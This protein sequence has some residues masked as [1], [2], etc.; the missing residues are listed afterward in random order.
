MPTYGYILESVEERI[1]ERGGEAREQGPTVIACPVCGEEHANALELATHLGGT[2]PLSAPRLLI[3]GEAVVGERVLD[4]HLDRGRLTVANANELLVSQDG[5]PAAPWSLEALRDAVAEN[6]HALLDLELRNERAADQA[7]ATERVRLRID[8]PDPRDLAAVEE[9]F[10]VLA[11]AELDE[12]VVDAF[13]DASREFPSA[14]RYAS[15]LHEYA[16]GVLIKNRAPGTADALGFERFHEKYHRALDVLHHF[17]ER[18]LACAVGGFLRFNLND[19]HAHAPESGVPV[20]DRCCARLTSLATGS[21]ERE[22]RPSVAAIVGRCPADQ[23]TS[24]IL[25]CWERAEVDGAVEAV[26][27]DLLER[28]ESPAIA[29][30]D[31]VKCRALSLSLANEIGTDARLLDAARALTSDLVFGAW[32]AKILEDAPTT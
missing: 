11:G 20:L 10:D 6:D 32:A 21:D 3:D 8:V 16:V 12:R 24:F 14:A 19:F 29:T 22:R 26:V 4:C 15:A 9:A 13:V 28:S 7:S 30:A 18:P 27:G 1:H 25:D 5:A 31:A 23:T 17:P 2:H